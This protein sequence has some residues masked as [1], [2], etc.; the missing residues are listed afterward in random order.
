MDAEHA[1]TAY[2]LECADRG[3]RDRRFAEVFEGHRDRLGCMIALRLDPRVQRRL[4]SSDVLQ[5]VYVEASRRL[6][7]YLEAPPASLFLWLRRLTGQRLMDLHRFHLG[8]RGRSVRREVHATREPSPDASAVQLVELIAED[9]TTPSEVAIRNET[10]R[11]VHAALDTLDG[12]DREILSLRNFE[13]L[14]NAEAARVLD[15]DESAASKRFVRA[16]ERL[17]KAL[18]EPDF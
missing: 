4:D 14:S 8:A 9:Q 18:S 11:R 13:H 6:E 7:D 2:L 10:R 1:E 12:L 15:I 5:E 17:K 3:A 16:L